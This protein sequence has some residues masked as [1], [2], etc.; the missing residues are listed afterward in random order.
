[1]Q[2]GIVGFCFF[3]TLLYFFK[4]RDYPTFESVKFPYTIG[5][6]LIILLAII[7]VQETLRWRHKREPAPLERK[8]ERPKFLG[9]FGEKRWNPFYIVFFTVLFTIFLPVLNTIVAMY[10]YILALRLLFKKFS[11]KIVVVD[12]VA[13]LVLFI[14]FHDI[15]SIMMPSG[16]IENLISGFWGKFR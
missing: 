11:L 13:V 15:L 2:V 3:I 7:A 5:V 12:A 8:I 6:A 4:T 10:V 14:V 16:P 1:M 9:F